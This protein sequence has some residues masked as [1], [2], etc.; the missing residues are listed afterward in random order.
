MRAARRGGGGSGRG[1][2]VRQGRLAAGRVPADQHHRRAEPG[3]LYDVALPRQMPELAPV[4]THTRL[5]IG[6]SMVAVTETI[7]RTDQARLRVEKSS[8][9]RENG[10]ICRFLYH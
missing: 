1:G 7:M 5:A 6:R 10:N 2:D 4:T 8:S 9:G 3:H